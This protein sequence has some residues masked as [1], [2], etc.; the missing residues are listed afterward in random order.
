V[1]ALLLVL[2]AFVLA[3][4]GGG[5]EVNGHNI[6]ANDAEYVVFAWNDLGMHCLNPT[7]DEAVL[8]PPYNTAWA[9]VIQR[10]NPPHVVTEGLTAEYRIVDNTYSYG[11]TDSYGGVFAQFW[12][13][14]Q[15]LFGVSLDHDKGLNLEDPGIHN[16]LTGQMLLKGDHFQVNGIPATP[17]GDNNAWNPYQA[18][19]VTIKNGG[20]TVAQTRA[21]VPTSDEINCARCHSQ[22]GQTAFHDILADHDRLHQTAL[23][24]QKPVLCANCHGSPALG[25]TE[26]GP[27]G[28]YL[29]QA[30]HGAHAARDAAC[31]DCHPG[32]VTQCN[33]SLAHTAADG[34]CAACHGS[35]SQVS[36]T[37][38]DGR[39]PWASEPKCVTCHTGIPEVDTGTTLYRNAKGH[40]DLY[41]AACHHSPHAMHPSREALDDY[42]PTQYQQSNITI[43]SCAACHDNSR[44]EGASEFGE[45]HGGANGGPTACRVCH[46]QVPTST[47][48]WPHSFQ[49]TA[50]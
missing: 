38:V 30:I 16:G 27:S 1:R 35:M 2:G 39:V 9:Q 24:D 36:Q 21:T 3:R 11:K 32:V 49:W 19:E 40:G 6:P 28:Q 13:N 22:T 48:S 34:D 4:C 15:T 25:G 47:S 42:Q 44:G 20:T 5:T 17:V 7:Y 26:P 37:I 12:D 14:V 10:G 8:L 31:F 45:Q 18:I 23:V 43:G 33:R 50:R 41:C 29:S 46:T